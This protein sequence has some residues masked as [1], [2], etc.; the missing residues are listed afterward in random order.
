MINPF[1]AGGPNDVMARLFAQRM[2]EILGQPIIVENVGGAG[3]MNGADRVAKAAPDGYTFLQGTVGT[4]AQNQSLFKK[5]AYNSTDGFRAGRIGARSAA[6]A[7]RA[8]GPSGQG[9]EGIR[10]LRQGQQGQDAIASAGTGSAIHL[11]CALMNMVDRARRRPCALSRRQSGDAGSDQRPG[12]L[13][14]RH[15]HDRKAADR[16]RHREA[17]RDPDQGSDRRRCPTFRP[18]SNKASMSKPIPGTRSSCRRERPT[19]IVKKLHHATLEAMKTPA[20]REKLESAGL[21]FVSDD[22]TTPEYLAKFVAER[23]RQMGRSDQGQRH[24]RRLERGLDS[25]A[26]LLRR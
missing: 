21:Q 3:G 26:P 16:C 2:G 12:R 20:V 8:Q 19:P 4:Q 10:R 22:R 14:L 25:A 1:A 23:D 9:H 11:G 17:D 7:D 13:S 15:H 24:Q 5:P 6:G 18:Q